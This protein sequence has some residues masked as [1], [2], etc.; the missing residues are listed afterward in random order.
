MGNGIDAARQLA[1]E[2]AVAL[3]PKRLI[4]MPTPEFRAPPA[5]SESSASTPSEEST[6]ER[7]RVIHPKYLPNA[8]LRPLVWVWALLVSL[9]VWHVPGVLL[10]ILLA[11]LAIVAV[12]QIVAFFLQ[13][14][15]EP[16]MKPE[17]SR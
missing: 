13:D 8:P 12:G 16:D 14:E 3:V 6:M 17:A 15:C 7:K 11:V 5:V 4:I 9:R 10:G 1:P 2:H